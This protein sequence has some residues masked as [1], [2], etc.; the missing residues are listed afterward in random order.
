MYVISSFDRSAYL[1]LAVTALEAEGISR[2]DILIVP[3]AE[4]DERV[5]PH[6]SIRRSG[7][8]N[9]FDTGVVCATATALFSLTYRYLFNWTPLA[10][11]ITGAAIGYLLHRGIDGI[12]QRKKR[13]SS[14]NAGGTGVLA[15]VHC[16]AAD[17]ERVKEIFSIHL[18]FGVAVLDS[19][20]A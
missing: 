3:L 13:N 18:A 16:T 10:W 9:L 1:E 19:K 17:A 14:T 5:K 2:G 6:H 7:G 20:G 12:Y 15:A 8:I 11:G 4:R